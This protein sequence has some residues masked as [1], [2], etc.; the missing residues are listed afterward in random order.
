MSSRSLHILHTGLADGRKTK[1]LNLGRWRFDL[2]LPVILRVSAWSSTVGDVGRANGVLPGI[3]YTFFIDFFGILSA[4]YSK[5][6]LFSPFL[7]LP[8]FLFLGLALG[9]V[10]Y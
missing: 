8:F 1:I 4:F 9:C 3:Y 7:R 10:W 2:Q 6:F 5:E